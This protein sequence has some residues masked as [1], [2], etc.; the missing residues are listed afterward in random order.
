M[1]R[2]I[3]M[4]RICSNSGRVTKQDES[5]TL[6]LFYVNHDLQ[7]RISSSSFTF[8]KQHCS[9]VVLQYI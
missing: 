2:K 9:D 8:M 5:T 3:I 6:V 1:Y 4:A 7:R